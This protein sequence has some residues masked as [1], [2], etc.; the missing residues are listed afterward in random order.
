MRKIHLLPDDFSS[1]LAG[2]HITILISSGQ[3]HHVQK[4]WNPTGQ[5]L[6]G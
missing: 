3:V 1:L 5:I 6:K 4:T 2:Q